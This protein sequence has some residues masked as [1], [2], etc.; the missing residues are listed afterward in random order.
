[1]DGIKKF[2][3]DGRALSFFSNLRLLMSVLRIE[4]SS[5]STDS[6]HFRLMYGRWLM[7]SGLAPLY[8]EGRS[9]RLG[10]QHPTALL[11]V[12]RRCRER[13]SQTDDRVIRWHWDFSV[14]GYV[15]T[16]K[17]RCSGLV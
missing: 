2:K 13:R 11:S 5:Q 14:L 16:S 1:M 9:L 3:N 10:Q 17:L 12:Q 8:P 7:C 15:R 6:C 4:K